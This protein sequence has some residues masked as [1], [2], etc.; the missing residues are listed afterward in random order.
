MSTAWEAEKNMD[1]EKAMNKM[2]WGAFICI[3]GIAITLC[4]YSSAARSG[5]SYTIAYGAILVG[6][7]RFLQ[8]L[9]YYN[10]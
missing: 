10:S 2:M 8:G 1:R 3:I 7:F 9:Y 5:G 6:G 4:T